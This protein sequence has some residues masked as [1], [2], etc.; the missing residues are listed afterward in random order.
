MGLS[1]GEYKKREDCLRVTEGYTECDNFFE[2]SGMW[3]IILML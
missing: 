3:P 2:R 1:L